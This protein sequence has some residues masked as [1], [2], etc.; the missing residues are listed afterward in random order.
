MTRF[1]LVNSCY[2]RLGERVLF[3]K[4]ITLF[5]CSYYSCNGR[6][7]LNRVKVRPSTADV[8]CHMTEQTDISKDE[9]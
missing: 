5:R 4:T 1:V 7:D 8:V 6:K 9:N 3:V 2:D